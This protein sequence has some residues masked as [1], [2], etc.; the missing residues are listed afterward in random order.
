MIDKGDQLDDQLRAYYSKQSLTSEKLKTMKSLL[1]LEN[2]E[3]APAHQKHW[4]LPLLGSIAALLFVFVA[5]S[6]SLR[7]S[8]G[9]LSKRVA[10][11]VALNHKKQLAVEFPI[12]DYAILDKKMS[13]LD[14]T[15]IASKRLN[16]RGYNL[17][18]GRYCSIGGHIAGQLRLQDA[19]E[20]S[21]TLYQFR[22]GTRYSKLP[23]TTISVD[24]VSV[25]IWQESGLVLGLARTSSD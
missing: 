14:F 20:R 22:P 23:E 7:Q 18:G 8:S 15:I 9:A 24:G 3:R 10:E 6:S 19:Q 12:N 5:L 1:Q 21:L 17:L 13:K 25:L 4:V 16:D 2:M 11:E